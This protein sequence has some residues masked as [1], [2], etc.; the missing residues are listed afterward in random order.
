MIKMLC[1]LVVL[2]IALPGSTQV[3]FRT[4]LPPVGLT[5]K[6][7]LWNASLV[8]NSGSS[9][10]AQVELSVADVTTNQLV[11]TATTKI[12]NLPVGLK[13][14][15]GS[16]IQPIT[17]N[18][19]S[20]SYNVNTSSEGFLPVGRFTICYNVLK[21]YS[22]VSERLVE[23]CE[24]AEVEALSPPQ[25]ILPADS[26][27]IAMKR[28]VFV[29]MA[30]SPGYLFSNLN[31]SWSLVEVL[32][33]QTP[34]DALTQNIPIF[35]HSGI[36]SS[37]FQYPVSAPALDST[38]LYAWRVAAKNNFTDVGVSESWTFRLKNTTPSSALPLTT[39][40]I[41][42]ELL[43]QES[44]N[45]SMFNG[46]VRIKLVN[47]SNHKQLSMRLF[48]ISSNARKEIRLDTTDVP[49]VYGENYINLDF[50]R[51][52]NLQTGKMYQLEC[53]AAGSDRYFVKFV[54]TKPEV[55]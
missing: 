29:W 48:D 25:L 26:D 36:T 28:P 49:L 8:N 1:S 45:Y 22:D 20:S 54:F 19:V 2:L 38:R 53:L 16:D 12:F 7:Q 40:T 11:F 10:M 5:T 34:S 21:I 30:P 15:Q 17:Y 4:Q 47:T 39:S 51:N 41:Y 32:P 44:A 27:V 24:T 50:S 42:A 6:S 9:M 14:L 55:E 35:Y 46:I 33:M 37:N 3:V 43:K 52:S 18:V 13:H 31:Y 23:E